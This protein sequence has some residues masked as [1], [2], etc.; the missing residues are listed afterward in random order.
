M[1]MDPTVASECN[2]RPPPLYLCADCAPQLN[3]RLL[4]DVLQPVETVSLTCDN[5]VCHI[6]LMNCSTIVCVHFPWLKSCPYSPWQWCSQGE[7][8]FGVICDIRVHLCIV[9]LLDADET[10]EAV[11]HH[12]SPRPWSPH[13]RRHVHDRTR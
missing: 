2:D 4:L 9:V 6:S 7:T 8:F 11:S 12:S 5:K 13:L 10:T 3:T 1:C